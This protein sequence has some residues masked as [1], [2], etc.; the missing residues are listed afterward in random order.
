MFVPK[1]YRF[2]DY[3]EKY[4]IKTKRKRGRDYQ[5]W[6]YLAMTILKISQGR[7]RERK[8]V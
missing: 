1:V 6:K 4:Q 7:N 8:K 3:R 2:V 5:R